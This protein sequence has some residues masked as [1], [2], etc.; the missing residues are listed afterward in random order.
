MT[1]VTRVPIK[2]VAAGSLTKLWLG[3]A[4]AILLGGG[5][6]W[7]AMPKGLDIETLVAG[8][9]PNPS[10][11]DVAFVKYVGKLASTGET[12]DESQN[13]PLPV[14][15]LFPEGTPFPIEDGA[16]IDGFFTSLQQMQKGGKY[17]VYIPA[18]QAYGAE[19]P[20]GAPIPPNADLIF[21][22]ELVDFLSKETFDRNLQILQQTL[23][24]QGPG[25][26]PG[27]PAQNV[28]GNQPPPVP[29]PGN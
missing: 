6:A 15:G 26:P 25:G 23:Q 11:G 7:A 13:I 8:E 3:V 16:T 24:R 14:Q 28:P 29:V 5:L 20:P 21:E 2:P 19:P 9:G 18:D 4:L 1:E 27:G 22:I 10:E 17:E 12:F